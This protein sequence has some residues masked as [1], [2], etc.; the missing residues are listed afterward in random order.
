MSTATELTVS[1]DNPIRWGEALSALVTLAQ[2]TSRTDA[3]FTIISALTGNS[4]ERTYQAFVKTA[5]G[6]K[7]LRERPSLMSRLEDRDALRA[8]PEGSLGREYL[9]FMENGQLTA[10]GLV[11]AQ[12]TG[13]DPN[14]ALDLDEDRRYVADRIRDQHDLWHVLTDYG[15]DDTGEIANLWFSVGQFGNPGM[16]FIAF[17]GGLDGLGYGPAW[18]RYCYRAFLRGKYAARLVS[19][20]LEEMLALPIDEVRRR[21]GIAR[22]C[23]LHPEGIR[24]GYRRDRKLGA[25]PALAA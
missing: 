21:L 16:A 2:D 22:T 10:G 13:T 8:M 6:Q 9:K 15:C 5:H 23:E 20:P 14:E 3:V 4:F 17:M 24:F 19:E 18:V 7:L 25:V 11:D 1:H 12:T